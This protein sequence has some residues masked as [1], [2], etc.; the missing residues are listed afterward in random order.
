M[1]LTRSTRRALFVSRTTALMS[2]SEF[3]Q[4]NFVR[5]LLAADNAIVDVA[6]NDTLDTALMYASKYGHVDCVDIL[7]AAKATVDLTQHTGYTAL[8]LA[9][10]RGHFD[11]VY[12]LLA[13][14]A[15]VDL[16]QHL[17]LTAL[18]L[19]TLGGHDECVHA[20][21]EAKADVDYEN[22]DGRTALMYASN[23]GKI[24]CVHALLNSGADANYASRTDRGKTALMLASRKGHVNC[25]WTLL[26]AN[27]VVDT[28]D[29]FGLTA[30]MLASYHGHI[31]CVNALLTANAIVDCTP[32]VA[33]IR[34]MDWAIA[35]HWLDR[36]AWTELAFASSMKGHVE[37]VRALLDAGATDKE[38]VAMKLA[39]MNNRVDI[40]K[41]L[42]DA[43][44][45]D[46]F[47]TAA[48][49]WSIVA[50]CTAVHDDDAVFAQSQAAFLDK[51]PC[52]SENLV[53]AD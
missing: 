32:N 19:A 7:L 40:L 51:L 36:T 29:A 39:S 25:V 16:T 33:E 30:L 23:Q 3:G 46:D 11:C 20:V 26:E 52:F 49:Q 35:E 21:L 22:D 6:H 44:P 1:V 48:M 31:G 17:G 5:I 41:L 43:F 13:A 4:D 18:M 10:D 8:M 2:A 24:T 12:S 47:C 14:K 27:A 38:G 28:K 9:S 34:C 45:P 50:T 37:C 53:R 15:S 42:I